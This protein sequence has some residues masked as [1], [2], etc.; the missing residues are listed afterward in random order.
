MSR[1]CCN[2]ASAVLQSGGATVQLLGHKCV[3]AGNHS[4]YAQLLQKKGEL[5][6]VCFRCVRLQE[7][8][9]HALG[10]LWDCESLAM[11]KRR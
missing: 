3:H 1:M 5:V 11:S 2:V 7:K 4:M 6:Y 9:W 8:T 10:S